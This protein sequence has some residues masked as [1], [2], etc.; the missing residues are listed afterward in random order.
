MSTKRKKEMLKHER[1][2][3]LVD[4]DDFCSDQKLEMNFI[5][6]YQVRLER[7]GTTLDVY[8]TSKK[9]CLIYHKGNKK[10]VWGMYFKVEDLLKYL[11]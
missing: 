2:K 3:N 5:S 1:S 11:N 7:N 6:D 4:L 9:Y 10:G 8:P